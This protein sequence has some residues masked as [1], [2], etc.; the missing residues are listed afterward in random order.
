VLKKRIKEWGDF[1]SSPIKPLFWMLIG[2]LLILST[3]VVARPSFY[4]P[5]L[6]YLSIFGLLL[7]WKWN[8]K[9]LL[10]T[11]LGIVFY[12]TF[13]LLFTSQIV[14]LWSWGWG[15]SFALA[16]IISY[17]SIEELKKHYVNL[18]EEKE[19]SVANLQHLL[20]ASKE[21]GASQQRQLETAVEE[22]EQE[23]K[24]AHEE[25]ERFQQLVALTQGE[26]ERL[27]KQNRTLSSESLERH[28]KLEA[29]RL[30]IEEER[31]DYAKLQEERRA[32]LEQNQS[33]LKKLNQIRTESYQ[34]R[35]LFE[36]SQDDFRKFR[37]VILSQ[38]R[39]L[40]EKGSSGSS[41]PSPNV[42]HITAS[43][44]Q[45]TLQ[46]LEKDK[47]VIKK[48]YIEMQKDHAKLVEQL[49]EQPSKSLETQ[50]FDKKKELERTKGELVSLEREI[51]ILKKE[52]QQQGLEVL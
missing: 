40:Q 20:Y 33:R 22:L 11:L 28:R 21:K 44:H 16:L 38:R 4:H 37:S 52:M 26:L 31:E 29:L 8:L 13:K 6:P 41:I 9:G 48:A 46:A 24:L 39:Q 42:S 45:L 19:E 32:L 23:I 50:A 1:S 43:S 10:T 15:S 49:K 2:P 25:T 30:S 17:V 7:V 27:E 34:M 3:V 36:A 47:K 5:F 51:F 18:K 35:M 12:F 14:T